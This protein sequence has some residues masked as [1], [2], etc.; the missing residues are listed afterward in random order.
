MTPT[1][2]VRRELV[3][4]WDT[5]VGGPEKLRDGLLASWSEPH[6]TYHDLAHLWRVLRRVED[7]AAHAV[8]LAAVRLAAWYHDA[9]HDGQPDDEERSALRA[10][11]E[12]VDLAPEL[13]AEV[14]R[15]VRLT[16][17]HNPEPG[18]R[19]GEVLGDADLAILAAP[20]PAYRRYA[21]AIRAEYAHVS[22]EA[23]RTG[24]AAILQALLDGPSL[25]RTP[26]GRERWEAAARANLAA[27]IAQLR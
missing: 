16:I 19:N 10:E 3:D 18:D 2:D 8:D 17:R 5:G 25:F 22:D 27:E 21:E 4:A 23:F 11:L 15:L 6:R 9:V 20:E 12:L 7:L 1:P 26:I 14:A 24:R 13:V